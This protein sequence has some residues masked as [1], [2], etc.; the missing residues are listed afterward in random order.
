[1]SIRID[2]MIWYNHHYNSEVGHWVPNRDIT[3]ENI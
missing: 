3:R 2:N 1:M